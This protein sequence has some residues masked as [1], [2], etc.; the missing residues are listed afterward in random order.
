MKNL[1]LAML[2]L[3]PLTAMAQPQTPPKPEEMAKKQT[4]RL[5]KEVTLT[6]DQ[7]KK[8]NEVYLAS[9]TK[10]DAAFKS[11]QV[12]RETMDAKQKEI[13]KDEET[14]L[15]TILTADQFTK[16]QAAQKKWD[17]ERASHQGGGP[18]QAPPQ[19]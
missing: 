2:L 3:L 5:K 1:V 12:S 8:V 4:E 19:K 9:A 6:A 11:G 7:E 15:K 17:A 13:R 14:K 10:M 16:Y 18:G